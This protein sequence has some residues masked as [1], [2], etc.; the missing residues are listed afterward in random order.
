LFGS[1]PTPDTRQ[2]TRNSTAHDGTA[3]LSPISS[4]SPGVGISEKHRNPTPPGS[5]V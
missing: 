4:A 3:L 1:T 5:L 2:F